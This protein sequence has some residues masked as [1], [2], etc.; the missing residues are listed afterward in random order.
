MA[1]DRTAFLR[2]SWVNVG[3]NVAKIVVEGA[4]GVAFGS[5]ALIADAAHSLA[6]LLASL[7]VLVW[8]RLAFEGPDSN[9]P[10]G[11]ERVEPLTA[12]FVGGTLVVLAVKILWDAGTAIVEGPAV[13]YSPVLPVGLGVAIA[14]MLFVYW[15]TERSN[16]AIGSPALDALAKDAR[17]DVLTS[18]AVVVSVFGAA[19]GRPILDPVAGALVSVLVVREG[20]GIVRENVDYLVGS[21]PPEEVLVEIRG[22]IR[23]HPAVRGLHDLRCH[24]VGPL[25]EV[26]FHAEV[27]GDYTLHEAH[28]IETEIRERVKEVAV[29]GDVHVHLDP[30]GLGEWKDADELPAGD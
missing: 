21:A 13:T 29:V 7:V 27:D 20:L 26:E 12:L 6:D 19:V 15:Y 5:I 8:G 16:R 1:D 10:H 14:I 22:A 11:H 4:I 17:N 25:V 28:D 30:S 18:V 9:H 3:G 23:S 24:Y 2:T